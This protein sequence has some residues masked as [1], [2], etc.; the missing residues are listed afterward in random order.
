MPK[1][2]VSKTLKSA[3]W[4][5]SHIIRDNIEQEIKKLEGTIAVHGS[6]KLARFL[7]EKKLADEITI[8]VYPIVLGTGKRLFEN[9]NKTGLKLVEAKSF[10]SGIV[11]LKYKHA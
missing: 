4:E 8:L 9:M 10:K 1:F 6:G 5:N 2:V 11:I 3:D 7:I